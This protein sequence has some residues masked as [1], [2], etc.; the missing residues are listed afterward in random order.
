LI[1]VDANRCRSI[2]GTRWNKD[3]DPEQAQPAVREY[4][5]A[6]DDPTYGAATE[7][8]PKFGSPSDPA[9]QWTG[10][11]RD[12]A[13]LAYADNYRHRRE[14]RDH[15][16]RQ[17]VARHSSGR[18]GRRLADNDHAHSRALWRSPQWLAGG[19]GVV[20]VALKFGDH[21]LLARNALIA[22]GDVPLSL[23]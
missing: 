5:T 20:A 22:F 6:L 15:H 12:A 19:L 18:G 7:V 10:A 9:A 16:G 8:T 2:P 3:F 14:V 4:L 1:E 21:L 13:F 23:R 11:L 17:G